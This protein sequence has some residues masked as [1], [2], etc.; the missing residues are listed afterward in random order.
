MDTAAAADGQ[1][2]FEIHQLSD[3]TEF[4]QTDIDQHRQTSVYPITAREVH[5]AGKELGEKQRA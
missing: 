2:L 5:K 1:Y 4:L 3:V